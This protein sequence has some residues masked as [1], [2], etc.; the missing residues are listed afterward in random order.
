MSVY[1]GELPVVEVE[2][3]DNN[4]IL[5]FLMEEEGE[6]RQV[7]FNK[8]KYDNTINKWV[9]DNEQLVRF[10]ENVQEY[11]KV[12]LEEVGYIVGQKFPVWEASNYC[13]LWEIKEYSKFPSD[14]VGQ[15]LQLPLVGY[16]I[17]ETK[18]VLIFE[19][20]DGQYVSNINFG[21][22]IESLKKSLLDPMKK[23]KQYNRFKEKFHVPVSEIESLVGRE[24]MVEVKAN[25]MD[26]TGKNP[27]YIDVKALPKSK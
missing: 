2:D 22:Y 15:I 27:T 8:K 13:A 10:N 21:Q 4:L 16:D 18:I 7:K 23:E 26:S 9:N 3:T 6:I 12:P 24:F 17:Q 14:Y 20:G 11:L 25:N 1:L 19:H 5:T